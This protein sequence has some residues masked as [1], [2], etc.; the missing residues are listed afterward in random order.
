MSLP[1]RWFSTP[2]S[3]FIWA[4]LYEPFYIL[5]QA[6]KYLLVY[7]LRLAAWPGDTM[8]QAK[9]QLS[10]SCLSKAGK[11]S[12]LGYMH[13]RDSCVFEVLLCTPLVWIPWD[14]ENEVLFWRPSLGCED[15]CI[16]G[17][18]EDKIFHGFKM[19]LFRGT[20]A[21]TMRSVAH[22]LIGVPA[23]SQQLESGKY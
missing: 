11:A 13:N 10:P 1:L 19:T 12:Y 23:T 3:H 7:P 18:M 15:I 5:P 4:I 8:V 2:E 9:S 21:S 14:S 6:A 20:K 17:D 22:F 16:M